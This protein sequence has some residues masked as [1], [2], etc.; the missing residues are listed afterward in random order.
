MS[1]AMSP[2]VLI[3]G[4]GLLVVQFRRFWNR[5]HVVWRC[6]ALWAEC[7]TSSSVAFELWGIEDFGPHSEC[8]AE[9][10]D[11]GAGT[12]TGYLCPYNPS[13]C[14]NTHTRFEIPP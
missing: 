11:C 1:L 13:V 12:A 10:N 4:R 3:R 6:A 8:H 5:Y 7:Y 2:S 14:R 9:R